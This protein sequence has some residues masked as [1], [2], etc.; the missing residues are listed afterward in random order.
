MSR[1]AVPSKTKKRAAPYGQP[2]WEIAHLFPYQGAWTEE[3][4]LSLET[5]HLIEFCDG[6]LEFPPMPTTSHQL[7]LRYL[8]GLLE[9]FAMQWDLGLTLFMG[10][11]I[12]L[13]S[14][15]IR[16]PDVVFMLKEHLDRVGEEY[17]DG[18]DRVME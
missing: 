12:R 6:R 10:V 17:W 2:A 1:V 4:Y 15:E 9:A 14:G 11:R 3:E 5:N 18:A 7:L 16:E 8:F 13:R